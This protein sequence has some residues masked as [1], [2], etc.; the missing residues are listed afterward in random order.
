MEQILQWFG[1][2]GLWGLF[3]LTFI[4]SFISP[5]LPD[6]M[7]IPL[8]LANPEKAITYSLMTTLASVLG[9]FVGY[10]IGNRFGKPA[11]KKFV[12]MHYIAKIKHWL[13][14]YGGWA[15]FLAALAPIPYKF[16]SIAAGTFRINFF[17][18]LMASIL[19]RGKRFLLVGVLIY[20]YGAEAL[21]MLELIPEQWILLGLGLG[22]L[23]LGVYYY[24]RRP[25]SDQNH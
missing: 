22:F 5:I 9:G 16:V 10:G 15:I 14:H 2:Y 21:A 1:Q 19:G 17:V 23:G 3:F 11:L 12:P 25:R 6:L 20:Y 13:D 8:A 24:C 7:L 4:E 18:F